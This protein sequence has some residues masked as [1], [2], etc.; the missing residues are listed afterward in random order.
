MSAKRGKM[1][2][3]FHAEAL[4]EFKRADN[5]IRSAF[6][7]KLE[8]LLSGEELPS[9]AHALHGFPRGFYKIKLRKAGFRLVYQFDGKDL[10]I[11]VIAVGRRDRD[12]VYEVAR[13]RLEGRT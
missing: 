12:I 3:L 9:P 6:R 10:V 1:R 8:K 5:P 2:L 11:L 7:K 4:K 13:A